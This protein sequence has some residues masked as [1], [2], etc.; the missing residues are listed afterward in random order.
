MKSPS[1]LLRL[2]RLLPLPLALVLSGAVSAEVPTE[3]YRVEDGSRI[4]RQ[5]IVVN[6]ALEDVWRAFTTKEGWES[7][8]VPFAHVELAAGG[9]IETSYDASAK[10]GDDSNIHNRILSFL[11]YRMLSIQAVK[12]PPGFAHAD[13]LPL[14][15]T[16]IE[17]EPAAGRPVSRPACGRR[18]WHGPS[19]PWLLPPP[20]GSTHG[21]ST[22]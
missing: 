18:A 12:A 4:I 21:M 20:K 14:L 10:R 8:A 19:A 16:V 5:E 2:L 13:L 6:A 22:I 17:F 11:P 9:L 3:E 15:H 7:W 1:Q